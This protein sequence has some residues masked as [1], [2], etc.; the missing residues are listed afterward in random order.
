MVYNRLNP[1]KGADKMT[2]DEMKKYFSSNIEYF[3]RMNGQ[4]QRDVAEALGVAATTFNTWCVGKI[5]PSLP[6][7]QMIAAYFGVQ[8]EDLIQP[9]VGREPKTRLELEVN[10]EINIIRAYRA[11]DD[12]IKDAVAKLLDVE[13]EKGSEK[14]AKQDA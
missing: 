1:L 8:V 13:R 5:L 9:L 10:E 3:I 7:L 6:K 2:E 12:G 4:Q 14:A 11:A